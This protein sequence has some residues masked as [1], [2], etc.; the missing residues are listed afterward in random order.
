MTF[1]RHDY[2]APR[3]HAGHIAIRMVGFAILGCAFFLLFGYVVQLLWNGVMP[4][5][6]GVAHVTFW[7]AI[8]L[9]LLARLLV[10]GF[11]P[12]PGGHFRRGYRMSRDFSRRQ[13]EN[14]WHEVGQRSFQDYAA[15]HPEEG[16]GA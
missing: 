13:Y 5:I 9:L 15:A 7:R 14:W 4:P 1:F 6:F 11:H 3:R 2:P 12:R 8:G 10:G 16:K